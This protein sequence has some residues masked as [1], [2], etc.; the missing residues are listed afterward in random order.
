MVNLY[1]QKDNGKI[2]ASLQQKNLKISVIAI[3][4]PENQLMFVVGK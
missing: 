4:L 1:E 3:W 2:T